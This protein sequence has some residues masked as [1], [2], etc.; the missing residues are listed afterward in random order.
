[1]THGCGIHGIMTHIITIL[2]GIV[3]YGIHHGILLCLI[4]AGDVLHIIITIITR[5]YIQAGTTLCIEAGT[6]AVVAQ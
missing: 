2:L 5:H 3:R 6:L 4:G 1:M